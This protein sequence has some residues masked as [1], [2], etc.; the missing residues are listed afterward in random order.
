MIGAAGGR[1]FAA[2]E[3]AGSTSTPGRRCRSRRAVSGAGPADPALRSPPTVRATLRAAGLRARHALSQNFL[4]DPDV[5]EAIL[6]RPRRAPGRGVLEIGPGLGFLTGG[7]LEAGRRSPRSSSTAGWRRS[8]A[9]G[10]HGAARA[11]AACGSSRAT[12][13]TRTWP[14]SS[15][16]RTTSSPTCRTT[17][18]ARSCT[19]SSGAPPR[20]ERLVLM[21]QREVAERIAAP[22]GKM[23][24]LSVFVQYHARVRIALR[25]PADGLRAG[26][27]GRL[28]GHRGRAVRR[29]RPARRPTTRTSLWRLVQ[30]ASASA[31]RC[32]TTSCRGS[33]RSTRGARRRRRSPRPASTRDRRPQTLAV[34]EWL[35]LREALG[36]LGDD[37]RGRRGGR[38]DRPAAARAGRP[39]RA[40]E[41]QPDARGR[42]AAADGFHDLHSVFVPLALADRL[43]LAPAAGRAGHAPRRPARPGARRRQPRAARDR[44]D[45]RRPSAAGSAGRTGP[46]AG[47]GR[48][49]REAH[50][51]RG[52]ARRR[53]HAM[54]RPRI[55]GALEAWGAELGRRRAAW[56]SPRGSARTCRSSS[57]AAR[58]SSRAAA[59]GS[60][61]CH[62]LR[63]APGRPARDARGR[64]LPR[65]TSSPRS[66]RCRGPGDGSVL[67]SSTH[68]AEELRSG[69]GGRRPRRPRR[70]PRDG[71]RPV[72]R[73]R[74]RSCPGLV[75]LRRALSRLLGR[76][77]GLSGL[78]PDARGRSILQRRGRRPP[79]PSAARPSPRAPA[80]RPAPAA[81]SS[82]RRPS[83]P[84]RRSQP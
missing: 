54:P 80:R 84:A 62:G 59:S 38:R 68:L 19:R 69:L 71:Q 33:C 61:R 26:P 49:A 58:R 55:D 27:G 52:R 53:Q 39:A 40:G 12:R 43:S 7:L 64:R 72:R 56:P 28:G 65:P 60:R 30:A 9:S 63:G 32:S 10:S 45:A 23:S 36:P 21:V 82:P 20:P 15:R 2:G 16:R 5:L 78:R 70:R 48:P 46:G 73:P 13:S 31:A 1:R 25:V 74:P 77:I 44:R 29:R 67:M 41:A 50:P 24:Y 8:C 35:A 34:G 37:R 81:H 6:A 3:R 18:P 76:P 57:P 51:G 22:P 17:S 47:A 11:P 66:T 4:A 79:R 42:R 75:P 14:T 83:S